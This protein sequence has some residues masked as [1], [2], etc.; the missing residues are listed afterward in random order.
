MC[1][2]EVRAGSLP[3]SG[4]SHLLDPQPPAKCRVPTGHTTVI[5][6]TTAASAHPL[7]DQ[8]VSWALV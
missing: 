4:T 5:R 6:T 7:P 2:W 3:P 8:Q 1:V